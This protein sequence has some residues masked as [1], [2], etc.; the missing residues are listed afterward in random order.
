MHKKIKIPRHTFLCVAWCWLLPVG[1]SLAQHNPA[2]GLAGGAS[3]TEAPTATTVVLQDDFLNG[4]RENWIELDDGNSALSVEADSG[5][6]SQPPE[7]DFAVSDAGSLQS[8]AAHF[9]PVVLKQPGDQVTIEFEARHDH[10]RFVD[11]GFRFGLFDSN[12]TRLV[13]DG[14]LDHAPASLD[15]EGYFVL[16][17]LG[18][19]TTR[20]SALI[21]ETNNNTDERLWNGHTIASHSNGSVADLLMFTRNYHFT[22]R[23]TLALN[24]QGNVDFVLQNNFSGGLSGLRGTSKREP[25]LRFDTIYFGANGAATNFAIDNVRVTVGPPIPK[26]PDPKALGNEAVRVGLYI[27]QGAGRS[28]RSVLNALAMCHDTEVSHLRAEDIRSGALTNVDVLIQPGGSGGGQG[29]HLAE[30]GRD[31]IREFVR[32]GGGFIGICGG[33]YLASADYEWSLNILDAKVLDRKH[34]ARGHGMVDLSLTKAGQQLLKT[35]ASS[36][37]IQYWQGPL[38][39]PAERPEIEDYTTL[40]T[41]ETEIAEN[42]APKGVMV[43]TTAV[44]AGKFGQGRVVCFSPHPELTEGLMHLIEH[45]VNHVK[46]SRVDR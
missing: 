5:Q 36:L 43:G 17:D 22:Y 19:S 15:D 41:F 12:G 23:L 27:D 21:R 34:W 8:F 29:R 33:A 1:H 28:L 14:D 26:T 6:L 30:A 42:G 46:R 45:A 4:S 39:A 44:A 20:A 11:R 25:T 18:S 40:A 24:S 10:D 7:L 37:A 9:P 16:L 31:A 32:D 38:L 3:V 2:E 13:E 35:N